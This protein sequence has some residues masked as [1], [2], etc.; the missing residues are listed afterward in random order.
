MIINFAP[1]GERAK[2]FADRLTDDLKSAGADK[3]R[4]YF[5][6][7]GRGDVF[8]YVPESD[9]STA[10]LVLKNAG[11]KIRKTKRKEATQ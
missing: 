2:E 5:D 10:L 8:A 11:A 3:T 6:R 9:V 4:V 7:Q 1:K